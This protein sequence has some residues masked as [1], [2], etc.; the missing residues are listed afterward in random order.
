[1]LKGLCVP[2]TPAIAPLRFDPSYRD[3]FGRAHE[4][5]CSRID[6]I[7]NADCFR[8]R[9]F[10]APDFTTELAGVPA[11][12][13]V[14]YA[15]PLP[16]GSIL[17]GFLRTNT[18]VANPST[19]SAPPVGSG[20]RVQITDVHRSYRFFQRPVPEAYFLNDAPGSDPNGP[21]AGENL[22][23]QLPTL[24][25]LQAPYPVAA[26]GQ[27]KVEFWNIQNQ[28]NSLVSLDFV[29]ADPERGTDASK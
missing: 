16:P 3:Y 10:H 14:E 24:R 9:I 11:L 5:L 13:Y 28:S 23:V 15:L 21:F 27:F 1:M 4:H 12:G 2:T 7:V 22:Y 25:L 6:Q 18:P 20:Y 17:L 19:A 26:P 29:V 8:I